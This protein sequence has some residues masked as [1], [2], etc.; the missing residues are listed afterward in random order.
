MEHNNPRPTK[1]HRIKGKRELRIRLDNQR[2]THW[3]PSASQGAGTPGPP[4]DSIHLQEDTSRVTAV[5]H[6]RKDTR[7]PW[8]IP[9]PRRTSCHPPHGHLESRARWHLSP[10]WGAPHPRAVRTPVAVK[11]GRGRTLTQKEDTP[12]RGT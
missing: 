7:A 8:T 12:L 6:V 10:T 4:G 1:N 9:G 3:S 5:T 11:K 2:N